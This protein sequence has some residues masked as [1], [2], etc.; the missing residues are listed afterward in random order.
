MKKTLAA[1]A[2]VAFA[3]P[4]FAQTPDFASVDADSSGAVSWEEAQ[5]ALPNATEDAFKAADADG[6]G[7]LNET[8]FA[9]LSAG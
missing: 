6:S 7:D 9:S 1:I 3:S 2:L 5:A 8:E 4:A